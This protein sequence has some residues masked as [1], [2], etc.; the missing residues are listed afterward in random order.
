ML[1]KAGSPRLRPE[2]PEP[3]S[4]R[5]DDCGFA[6]MLR[7]TAAVAEPI[8]QSPN[9]AG[10]RKYEA[11]EKSG[12]LRVNYEWAMRAF[13]GLPDKEGRRTGTELI[14]LVTPRAADKI[15]DK[16]VEGPKGERIRMA[17]KLTVIARNYQIRTA[18]I[19]AP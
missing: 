19:P 5:K 18:M 15:Y 12:A 14:K 7:L 2:G 16:L 11:S 13:C 17:E 8:S 6:Q 4:Q 3:R 9:S 10:G 1:A